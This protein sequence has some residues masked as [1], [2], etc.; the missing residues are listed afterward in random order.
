MTQPSVTNVLSQINKAAA[1]QQAVA[2]AARQA[3]AQIADERASAAA[4][5]GQAA[6][7]GAS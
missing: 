4:T 5:E 2:D 6:T 1:A 7:P 3:S